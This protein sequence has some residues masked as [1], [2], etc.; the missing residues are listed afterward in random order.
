MS[1]LFVVWLSLFIVKLS[2]A[3]FVLF[4]TASINTCCPSL[5]T[6][7]ISSISYSLP[8]PTTSTIT[9]LS[10]LWTDPTCYW[11]PITNGDSPPITYSPITML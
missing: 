7:T 8:S 10:T 1:L 5:S 3:T 4:I 6:K 9:S 2:Y 11:S